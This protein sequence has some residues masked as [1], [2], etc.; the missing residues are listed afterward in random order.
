MAREKG[1]SGKSLVIVESPAKAK[2]INRYLGSAYRVMACMGHIRDLPP[3]ELGIDLERDFEPVYRILDGK[4]KIVRDLKKAADKADAVYLATDLDREG[5]AIAW[6]LVHALELEQTPH[7]RV[8]FNEITKA[9]IREAF[10][11][12][13][14]L[15]MD[16]VNAQQARRLLDRIVGYQ[17]SPLI[18]SKIGKGLS[19]GR[20]Q[21]VAVRLIVERE[22]EIR[23]FLPEESWRIF[24]CLATDTS[25][26]AKQSAAWLKFVE[27]AKDSKLGR[28]VKER[29][30]W[31]SKH[32]CLYAELIQVGGSEM[33]A[34]GVVD[35]TAL[36]EALGFV[37][38][39][40]DESA[41]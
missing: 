6:H 28:T 19:A 36:A 15:D 9:A 40:V 27:G 34:K 1:Q 10:K 12:P 14:E 32:A 31:L 4:R 23:K 39:G 11:A 22:A 35:A 29:S 2:T 26:T 20:V 25:K 37:T 17:L 3:S 13:D 33:S 38:Q 24:A 18:Q 7:H 8:V 5:E 41:P 16:K 21:S 30:A